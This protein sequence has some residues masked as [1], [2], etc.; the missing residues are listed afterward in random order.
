MGYSDTPIDMSKVASAADVADGAAEDAA[1]S[2]D[3]LNEAY[4]TLDD[5]RRRLVKKASGPIAVRT[6]SW[7][8]GAGTTWSYAVFDEAQVRVL[9]AETDR[10]R[11]CVPAQIGGLPVAS[12]GSDF[13]AKAPNCEQ[14]VLPETVRALE[15]CAFRAMR[16]LRRIVFPRALDTFDASWLRGCSNLRELVLP[17]AV[18]TLGASVFAEGRL[19]RLTIGAKTRILEPGMF[20][21]S[22]LESVAIDADNPWLATD[23]SCVLSADGTVLVALCVPHA[24]FRVPDG[25]RKIAKKAFYSLADLHAVEFPRGLTVVGR[26]AFARSGLR[27]FEA[28]SNL[29]R[30]GERAFFGC[31]HLAHV[32]VGPSLQVAE[33][34]AFSRTAVDELHF[35]K[36]LREL[37]VPIADG[38]KLRMSGEDATLTIDPDDPHLHLDAAGGLYA[39]NE[40]GAERFVRLLDRTCRAYAIEPGTTSI[41]DEAFSGLES[42]ERVTIPEGVRT[43]GNRAFHTCR[44]LVAAALP[45][46]VESIGDEAFLCTALES[47]HIPA[48]L[49]RLG[50]RALVTAGAYRGAHENELRTADGASDDGRFY[51]DG[52][53]I[54]S[55]KDDGVHVIVYLGNEPAVTLPADTVAVEPYAFA[56]ARA[57]RELTLP[58]GIKDVGLRAFRLEEPLARLRVELADPV[59]GRHELDLSFPETQRGLREE[60][61]ALGAREGIDAATILSHYDQAILNPNDFDTQT[62]RGLGAYEQARLLLDRLADP[63]LMDPLARDLAERFLRTEAEAVCLDI[64]RHGDQA[65]LGMMMDAGFVTEDNIETIID[66]VSTLQDAALIGFLLEQ[67]RRR[68]G[69]GGLDFSL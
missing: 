50:K 52:S 18:E 28:P 42:L 37:G 46:S 32:D 35:P 64:A 56:G 44:S 55:R 12:V 22:R 51:V 1:L 8:D 61:L 15:P 48:H 24:A 21:K 17:G 36:T 41:D 26:Y 20:E 57:L 67:Q 38:S 3:N 34:D 45:D 53:L 30:I 62:E 49:R 10:T 59:E 63:V 6:G 5:R 69:G 60:V 33:S 31:R 19:E 16:A 54:C 68:F 39:R 65:T 9:G 66:R 29:R 11:L 7:T 2:G 4:R 40:T 14:I 47:F 13:G 23:G 43:I 58:A 25:V 27:A